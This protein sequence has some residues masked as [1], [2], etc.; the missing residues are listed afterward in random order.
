MEDIMSKRRHTIATLN[1]DV[2]DSMKTGSK[3]SFTNIQLSGRQNAEIE[4]VNIEN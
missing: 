1:K 3:A 2:F 4:E